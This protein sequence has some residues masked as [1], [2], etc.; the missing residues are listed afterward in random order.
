MD[1]QAIVRRAGGFDRAQP[2]EASDAMIDVDHEIPGGKAR[3]FRDE[4][5]RPA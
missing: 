2:D 5:F 3:H 4:V 1:F